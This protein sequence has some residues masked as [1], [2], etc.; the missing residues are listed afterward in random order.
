[1]ETFSMGVRN[2]ERSDEN[3]KK[4]A[5]S[6]ERRRGGLK[7]NNERGWKECGK[8]EEKSV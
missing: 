1:M 5:V 8:L 4:R 7:E 2:E 3:R 6:R